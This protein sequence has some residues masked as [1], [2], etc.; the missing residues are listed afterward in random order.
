[1]SIS[2]T[3]HTCGECGLIAYMGWNLRELD[4][5]L[6]ATANQSVTTLP[7]GG[8]EQPYTISL[9]ALNYSVPG[10]YIFE[11]G[12]IDSA[13]AFN[14][15]L[16]DYNDLA[17]VEIVLDNTLDLR[18]ASMY[19][20]H[21]PSSPNYYYGEDMLSVDVENIGNFTVEGFSRV[22]VLV[23]GDITVFCS[24]IDVVREDVVAGVDISK[25]EFEDNSECTC[26]TVWVPLR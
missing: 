16:N 21:N 23:D 11:F 15:D 12:L 18:I 6:V 19:P 7:A 24:K 5:T 4:G 10:R 22:L 25:C 20:S 17:E 3:A 9:P 26:Y 13:S 1:M 14:G 2:G 8:Y